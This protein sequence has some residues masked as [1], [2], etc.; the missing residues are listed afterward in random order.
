MAYRGSRLETVILKWVAVAIAFM[1]S[2]SY[3]AGLPPDWPGHMYVAMGGIFTTVVF[4]T[5]RGLLAEDFATERW[6]RPG[7][8]LPAM[9]ETAKRG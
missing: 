8:A 3:A 2:L 7:R 6:K 4:F 5:M 1:L 9:R